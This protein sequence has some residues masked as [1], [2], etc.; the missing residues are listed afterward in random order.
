[1]SISDNIGQTPDVRKPQE[2]E[3]PKSTNPL[4]YN[5]DLLHAETMLPSFQD[6]ITSYI[7]GRIRLQH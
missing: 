5:V 1:M 6:F 4:T 7:Y 2:S 3:S